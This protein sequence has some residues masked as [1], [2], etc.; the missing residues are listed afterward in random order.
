MYLS[1]FR[2]LQHRLPTH[3]FIFALKVIKVVRL[4]LPGFKEH[5]VLPDM[6][7]HP[8]MN[9]WVTMQLLAL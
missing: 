7:D 8:S 6:A 3:T 4:A 9:I 1:M 5:A 2:I